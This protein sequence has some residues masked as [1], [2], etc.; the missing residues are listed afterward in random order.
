MSS[1]ARNVKD[2]VKLGL[3]KAFILHERMVKMKQFR[4]PCR[5]EIYEQVQL[6]DAQKAEID[7][8]YG[9]NYGKK[10]TYIWHR[11]FTAF[12]GKFDAAYFPEHLYI[13]EFEFYMNLNRKYAGVFEDKN[14]LPMVADQMGVRMPEVILRGICGVLLNG[15]GKR[16]TEEEAAKLLEQP[17]EWFTKVSVGTY[18]GGGC[19]LLRMQN[20]RDLE[21]GEDGKAILHRLGDHFVVQR[22]LRCAEAISAIYPGSVNTFRVITYR[23]R[24]EIRHMPVIMRI[25]GGGSYLDNVS[26]GG[27]FIAVEDDGTLHKTAFTEFCKSFERHPDTGLIFEGH[28]IPGFE[29]V[30]E[31]AEHMHTAIPQL[32]CI[33]WDLTIDETGEP[34][35]IEANILGGSIDMAQMAHGKGIFG[36]NTAEV[37]RWL[38]QM[39]HMS[40]P[41]QKNYMFGRMKGQ[42]EHGTSGTQ[43]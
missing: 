14:V 1:L 23:W 29:R 11:H 24:E 28:R 34:V 9:E 22:R 3:E 42:T 25:G 37:L 35:L 36:E 10:I 6:T 43:E 13:P 38:H 41:E 39:N 16:C 18:G 31:T 27:M 40:V 2:T 17:G 32:G 20:G 19:R 12:T 5:R 30:L 26:A 4:E 7:R 33:N 8:L 21:T 15:S